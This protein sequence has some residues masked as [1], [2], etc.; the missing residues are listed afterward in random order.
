[1]KNLGERLRELRIREGWSQRELAERSRI[2]QTTISQIENGK[3]NP[4]ADVLKRLVGALGV[5]ANF[6]LGNEEPVYDDRNI[7]ILFRDFRE[8]SPEDQE[9]ILRQVKLW[10]KRRAK[11]EKT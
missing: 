1:M 7:Q 4:S 3:R 5:S 9:L 2:S 10:R 6:L 8:L 11:K